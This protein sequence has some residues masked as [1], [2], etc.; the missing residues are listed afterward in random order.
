VTTRFGLPFLWLVI[1]CTSEP[2]PGPTSDGG[3][4]T[5]DAGSGA[6][7][8][9]VFSRT[10]SVRHDSIPAAVAALADMAEQRGLSLT[11]SKDPTLFSDAGLAD[12]SAVVFLLTTG[13]VLNDEQQGALERFIRAGNGYAGIHSASDTEYAWPWYGELVG[14]YFQA[15]SLVEP[16]TVL[17]ADGA[18]PAT[19]DL[20]SP[21]MR[22]DE[23]Y[24]FSSNPRDKVTVLLTV[25]ESTYDPGQGVMGNDHPVAWQRNFDGGRS[26]Y[27]ALGHTIESYAESA[28]MAHVSG[29]IEWA[30]GVQ[31]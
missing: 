11:A 28:F 6:P 24:A 26:F 19:R 2:P 15:H 17:V 18:Q 21:W 25:D 3:S 31:P 30:A 9:L 10:A 12:F 5:V 14:A 8:I 1:G 4:V 29:G 27:T 7:R 13:D 16:A 23:W 22:S 20:P